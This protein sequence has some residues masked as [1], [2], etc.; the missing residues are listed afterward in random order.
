M[1][2][3]DED[4]QNPQSSAHLQVTALHMTMTSDLSCQRDTYISSIYFFKQEQIL[5]A[6]L[7][8]LLLETTFSPLA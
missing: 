7:K 3:W 5:E 6:A 1:N 2:Y 8:P 4:N